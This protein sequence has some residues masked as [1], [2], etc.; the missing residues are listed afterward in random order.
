MSIFIHGME[1][2]GQ[3]EFSHVRIYGNGDV[4]VE[5]SDGEEVVGNAE[6][7]SGLLRR[8]ETGKD[9][10]AYAERKAKVNGIEYA[11]GILAAAC[12][13]EHETPAAG[14]KFQ[15][16]MLKMEYALQM[17]ADE[18]RRQ[19]SLW[20]DQ[21]GRHPF[22][23]MS[24]LGEEFGELCEAANETCFQNP[25]H[26]ERGGFDAVVREAVHVAAVAVQIVEA[27]LGR[28]EG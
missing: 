9:L 10:R 26:P 3:G 14:G 13:I 23:Y 24:I 22:E 17:V 18:R 21:S 28:Q 4:T 25:K 2:P 27:Y 20:G 7:G 5:L 19:F 15:I 6:D 16:P 8:E 12:R 1:M 11:N